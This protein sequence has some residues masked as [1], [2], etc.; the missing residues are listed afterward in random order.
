MDRE[1]LGTILE[2]YKNMSMKKESEINRENAKKLS[3]LIL[4]NP[5]MRVIAWIDPEGITDEYAWWAGNLN[6]VCIEE[7][8]YSKTN[9]MYIV[10]SG[11]DYDECYGYY[12]NYAV[13]D[14][15]DKKLKQMA[16]EIPWERV[17]AV[18]VSAT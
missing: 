4:E 6:K 3:G 10:K 14:W 2:A 16:G 12:G 8:A 17:I 9:E 11:N 18:K 5:E 13:D 15:D 7:I 1:H